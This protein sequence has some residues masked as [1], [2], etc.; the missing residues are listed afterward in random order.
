MI[1]LVSSVSPTIILIVKIISANKEALLRIA[2]IMK[3]IKIYVKN[4]FWDTDYLLI[5]NYV[6]LIQQV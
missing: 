4:V 1:K 2:L 6:K 3:S 5:K